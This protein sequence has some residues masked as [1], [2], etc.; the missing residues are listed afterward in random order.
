LTLVQKPKT[1]DQSLFFDIKALDS[2]F[3]IAT[4]DNGSSEAPSIDSTSLLNKMKE[5]VTLL[6][7]IFVCGLVFNRL[8]VLALTLLRAD[9]RF[10][11]S[12]CKLF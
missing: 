7:V 10:K 2:T 9:V 5:K 4:A 12:L 1:R 6:N 8:W 3:R 11:L